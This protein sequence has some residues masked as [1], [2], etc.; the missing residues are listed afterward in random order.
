MNITIDHIE[1]NKRKFS[2]P[3]KENLN[4]LA[5]PHIRIIGDVLC[6]PAER[7]ITVELEPSIKTINY[8]GRK[9]KINVPFQVWKFE[10]YGNSISAGSIFFRFK[11]ITSPNDVLYKTG[12]PNVYFENGEVCFGDN[13]I[14]NIISDNIID[15][16]DKVIKEFW[17]SEFNTELS[18]WD[19]CLEV[20]TNG[21][22]KS[23]TGFQKL[24]IEEQEKIFKQSEQTLYINN[25]IYDELTWLVTNRSTI[26][27][28]KK[29]TPSKKVK[30]I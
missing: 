21:K 17:E 22:C 14:N 18:P 3:N 15:L 23:I 29:K 6:G 28:S 26:I 9:Y 5:P 12:L 8:N 19:E 20:S 30:L 1:Y 16:I 10:M 2:L 25:N 11:R 4:L 27:D 7:S 13:D 24:S